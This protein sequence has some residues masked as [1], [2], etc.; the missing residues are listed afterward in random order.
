ME[1]EILKKLQ[2]IGLTESEAKLYL[3]S[4]N[5]GPASAIN[6]GRKINVTRQM[7][8]VL[9]PPLIEKGLIKQTRI[10][11]RQYYEAA[12]PEILVDLVEKSK[13]TIVDLVPVLKT[14]QATNNAVPLI[15]V[16][17]NPIAMREW[18]RHMLANT[19]RGEEMLIW[20]SGGDWIQMDEPFYQDYIAKK[21]IIGND[22]KLIVKDTPEARAYHA[23][24][25]V[26][27][28]EWRFMKEDWHSNAELWIWNDEVCYQTLREN[29]TNLI[30]IKSADL[31]AIERFN[32]YQIWNQL[33]PEKNEIMN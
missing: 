21:N 29:A 25:K 32:F 27:N 30:V 23:S 26:P 28:G 10:G 18:Y 12:R 14:Q 2:Q 16:Y 7:I 6:L 1:K 3:T 9:L 33:E 31:A 20:S 15:T 24:I 5:I 17:E 11:A 8:Y 13:Q 22:D 4:L 19:K